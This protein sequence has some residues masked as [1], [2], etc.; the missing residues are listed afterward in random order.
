M[1]QSLCKPQYPVGLQMSLQ[2]MKW[3]ATVKLH[4]LD[5]LLC[6]EQMNQFWRNRQHQKVS[7]IASPDLLDCI[8]LPLLV[9]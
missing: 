3:T 5:M 2:L 8:A 9:L 6:K 1:G 7:S 4:H